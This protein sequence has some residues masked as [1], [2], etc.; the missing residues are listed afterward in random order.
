MKHIGAVHRSLLVLSAACLVGC[1][2][3]GA[4]GDSAPDPLLAQRVD[5]LVAP[6]V[7]AHEF[8]GAIVLMR[9]GETVYRRGFGMANHA[10]GVP[11]TPD[12]PSDG[13]SLA[14]TFTAAGVWWLVAQGRIVLDVPVTRYVPD[15][16]HA[17]TTVRHL[18]A[19]SNGLPP[20]YDFFDPYFAKDELL[21]TAAL[22][23][24][25]AL[26]A[27]EPSFP[28]G[29]RFEYSGPGFDVAALVIERVT[30]QI[31][32]A[33]VKQRF[34]EP[35]GMHAS[36]ARPARL[37]DWPGVRTMGYRWRNAIWS[38]YDVFDGEAFLGASNLY[39]SAADLARWGSANAMGTALPAAV[40]D[41]GQKYIDLGGRH[42]GITGLSW[43]C[44]ES[45][46]H[47]HYPGVL[48]AFYSVVYWD[49]VHQ[50]SL[51][52]VSNSTLPPWKC[53]GLQRALVDALAG[54]PSAQDDSFE[55]EPFDRETRSAVAGTYSAQGLGVITI[56]VGSD[57]LHFRVGTGLDYGM[58]P[59]SKDVFYVPGLDYWVAFS[60][61]RPPTTVHIKS[62]ALDVVGRKT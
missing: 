54:R 5:A 33:F 15:Y 14:K 57:G 30:G 44:D 12:T 49:R 40:V 26:H 42:S 24:V 59:A 51:A 31:Y 32:E 52:F 41:A 18:I 21:T 10:A 62:M 43:Y 1:A 23:R 46:D 7:A 56:G 3:L 20:Q 48:N 53:I 9:R 35:L 55:F 50:A 47:C 25:V 34:F 16:P 2:T 38:E 19:H 58:F 60:G 27:A 37:A 4:D 39:F 29:S 13:A 22:L 61:G 17:Q 28:P 6:L 45:G 8:S 36:F 11:F